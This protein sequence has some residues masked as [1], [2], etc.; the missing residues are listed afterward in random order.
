MI[1]RKL[2]EDESIDHNLS[3]THLFLSDCHGI[4]L[5]P[6]GDNDNHICVYFIG[7]DDGH[8]SVTH[9]SGFSSFW[10]PE[11]CNLLNYVTNWIRDNMEKDIEK[12]IQ[13]GYRYKTNFH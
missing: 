1:R 4:C 9:E 13:C 12:G 8:W 6:R 5:Y 11:F 10:L 2:N 3:Y 7:E